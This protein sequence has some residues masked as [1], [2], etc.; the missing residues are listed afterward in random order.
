VRRSDALLLGLGLLAGLGCE[1]LRPAANAD[2]PTWRKHGG[3][4]LTLV[5]QRDLVANSRAAGEPYERAEPTIDVA[6]RRVFVGSSDGGLYALSAPLGETLWRFQTLS[7]VQSAPLYDP[8]EDTVYFGAHDGAL[9]KVEARG[10]RLLWRLSTRAEVARR[11]VLDKSLVYFANANDT[12]VAADPTTGEIRWSYHRT[13]ALGMEVAG[14]SGP[15]VSGELVYM[16]FSDGTATAFDAATGQERW[17]PVDLAAEAEEARGE[18]PKYLDV[19]TSPEL[20]E[21]EAGP[22]AVFGSYEGGVHALDAALGTTVWANTEA[23]GVSDVALWQQ[24]AALVDGIPRP[25]RRLLLVATGTTGLWALDPETGVE[26]WRR[27]LPRGG[28]SRPVAVAG[29]LLVNSTQLGTYLLSPVDG[30]LIDGLHF[31]LGASGTPA[32]YGNRAFVMTNGGTLVS[33]RVNVPRLGENAPNYARS[34][35]DAFGG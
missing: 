10:G 34:G 3:G 6:G 19:D 8:G 35:R 30:S 14:Y 33:L 15:V 7:F 5:Y 21:L 9:Y 18:V 22:V 27:D 11:P 28:I 24:P 1:G 13:P 20:V 4:A 26:V 17:Q 2:L 32:A 16:A 25:A 23:V 12:L 29:A 31:D